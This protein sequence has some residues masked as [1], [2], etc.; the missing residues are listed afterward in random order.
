MAESK[1]WRENIL[2]DF[3]W[4]FGYEQP[5]APL[6]ADERRV[7][8]QQAMRDRTMMSDPTMGLGYDVMT[9]PPQL[10]PAPLDGVTGMGLG[11][12]DPTPLWYTQSPLGGLYG[13][14]RTST[15][16]SAPYPDAL[17]PA[18]VE[19]QSGDQTRSLT[20]RSVDMT[21]PANRRGGG[22]GGLESQPPETEVSIGGLT[23]GMNDL[24]PPTI[25][26]RNGPIDPNI[27][28]GSTINDP[29]RGGSGKSPSGLKEDAED[30]EKKLNWIQRL[31][32]DK[33]GLDEEAR[34]RLAEA[35][36]TG[37]AVTM[38]GDSPNAFANIGKGIAAGVLTHS[39]AEKDD[40]ER[41]RQEAE[42][43]MEAAQYEQNSELR[44]LKIAEAQKNLR[45]ISLYAGLPQEVQD[46]E[47]ATDYYMSRGFTEKEARDIAFRI[48][49]MKD[50]SEDEPIP[51]IGQP[52]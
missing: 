34:K 23:P 51:I 16:G 52:G 50:Q 26:T 11:G 49:K 31:A 36:I 29:G 5:P 32:R 18:V 48:F 2:E 21:D 27:K 37:G 30:A 6:T 10:P 1:T 38:A 9:V 7:R 12:S 14:A 35:L 41:A 3:G 43:A 28:T 40:F 25:S 15:L 13:D 45:A 8:D 17:P 4:M 39:Q 44:E 47:G 22:D 42:D 20:S 24:L 46:V 33:L 19:L